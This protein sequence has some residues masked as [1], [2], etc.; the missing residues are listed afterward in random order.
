MAEKKR[1]Q[2]ETV[3][4]YGATALIL[5]SI[6]SIF[7]TLLAALFQAETIPPLIVQ[8]PL[9]GLPVGFIM[10]MALLVISVLKRRKENR[11]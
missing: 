11:N 1:V 8:L 4:A 7:A 2:L 3:L 10:I 9:I 5:L 6:L